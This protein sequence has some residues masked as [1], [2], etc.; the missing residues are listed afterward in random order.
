M[1]KFLLSL[2]FAATA[3][4]LA[5]ASEDHTGHDLSLIHI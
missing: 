5:L 1:R 2:A 4:A 3:P